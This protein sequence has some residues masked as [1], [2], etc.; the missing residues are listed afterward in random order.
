MRRYQPQRAFPER[1]YVPGQSSRPV[2]EADSPALELEAVYLP[3]PRWR[4]HA[5]YLWGVDLYNAGFFWE[6]HEV[7]EALWRANAHDADQHLYLQG[8]IQ[9]AAACLKGVMLDADSARRIGARALERL[10]RL[11][12]VQSEP[13]MGLDLARFRADLHAFFDMDPTASDQRP[14]I[15][16]E[17]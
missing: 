5:E 12:A 11:H 6:A 15:V 17:T 1:A 4:E 2:A 14:S 8:L 7:W 13:Y 16:L 3:H 9:T 10:D